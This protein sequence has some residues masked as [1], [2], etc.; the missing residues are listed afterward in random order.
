MNLV[1]DKWEE[2]DK[3]RFLEYLNTFRR[4]DEKC[5]WERRI[6]NT[7][8]PTLGILSENIKNISREISKGNY[9][10]FIDLQIWNNFPAVSIIG[11][12]I[13]KIQDFDT[14]KHY[15]DIY[16]QKVDNWANC[17][18]LK[19]KIKNNEE[20]Y[21]DII[22]EYIASP[23]TFR[24]RIALIIALKILSS[25]NVE[26]ILGLANSLQNE[27][28]YYVNMA[29]AWLLCDCFIKYR[30]QTLNLLQNHTLNKF[31]LNK[32]ISKCCDS[33]RVSIEDKEHLRSLRQK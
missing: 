17:D 1:K 4:S 10:S 25:H 7:A 3:A 26:K 5:E 32:M 12:L 30:Q 24:R 15:L 2:K 14:M 27:K 29:N 9:I 19:F 33:F 28:E 11:N 18:Q 23:L 22:N 13:V 31:T 16:S 21:W 6:V 20:K 8:L